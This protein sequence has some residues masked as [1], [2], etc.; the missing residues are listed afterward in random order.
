[1]NHLRLLTFFLVILFNLNLEGQTIH[2]SAPDSVA[3]ASVN[4]PWW[5]PYNGGDMALA[6]ESN[7]ALAVLTEVCANGDGSGRLFF[8]DFDFENVN[9]EN[10]TIYLNMTKRSEDDRKIRDTFLAVTYN[11]QIISNNLAD[12]ISEWPNVDT[13]FTYAINAS[14]LQISLT[15]EIINDSSFGFLFAT[16]VSDFCMNP[17][18]NSVRLFIEEEKVFN[19]DGPLTADAGVDQIINCLESQVTLGSCN[20]SVGSNVSYFWTN[21]SGSILS[22]TQ[23][24]TIDSPG[25]YELIVTDNLTGEMVF[26][27]VQVDIDIEIPIASAFVSNTITCDVF[28]ATLDGSGSSFGPA[29]RY[30]WINA[31][32]RVLS[33]DPIIEVNSC[34]EYTLHV[35]NTETGCASTISVE[36][37]CD[38]DKPVVDFSSFAHLSTGATS[39]VLDAT[40]ASTGPEFVY[41]WSTNDGQ[42][43]SGENSLFLTVG[44]EGAYR[45]RV[46]NEENGCTTSRT[47]F[48]TE[49]NLIADAGNTRVL[50]CALPEIGI[51]SNN[52]T[53]G[54]NIIYEWT[55]EFGSFFSDLQ[56]PTVTDPNNYI[57]KVIDTNTGETAIDD[58]RVNRNDTAPSV[59]ISNI[60]LN[61][62]ACGDLVTLSG[63]GSSTGSN[64]EYIWFNP[65]NIPISS[66]ITAEA[67]LCGEYCL[68]V[69]N[70]LN[71]C[72]S[73]DCIVVSE[74]SSATVI[75]DAGPDKVLSCLGTEF[76]IGSDNTSQGPNIS[77]QWTADFGFFSSDILFPLITFPD[78]YFLKVTDTSTGEMAF[79]TVMVFVN[80]LVP[81]TIIDT[82]NVLDCSNFSTTLD[83]SDSFVGGPNPLEI[84]YTWISPDGVILSEFEEPII[85]VDQCGTYT[86]VVTDFSN[87]CTASAFADVLC[88]LDIPNVFIDNPELLTPGGSIQ[89]DGSQSGTFLEFLLYEWTT[90][91]GQTISGENTDLVTVNSVGTYCLTVTN[92]E[93][94]CF[95][96]ECV[97]VTQGSSAT[98]VAD[99]GP[100]QFFTCAIDTIT[101]GGSNTSMGPEFEYEWRFGSTDIVSDEAFYTTTNGGTYILTVTNT[102][103]NE[104]AMDTVLV[105]VTFEFIGLGVSADGALSCSDNPT[106]DLT[107]FTE[108]FYFEETSTLWTG[109]SGAIIT[110]PTQNTITITQPGVYTVVVTN[111]SSGCTGT[112]TILIDSNGAS[113]L[114][115]IISSGELNCLTTEVFLDASVS[116]STGESLTYEWF[117]PN[118]NLIGQQEDI[119]VSEPGFYELIIRDTD[120]GCFSTLGVVVPLDQNIPIADVLLPDNLTCFNESTSIDASASSSG[121]NIEYLWS[122]PNNFLSNEQSIEVSECGT[123]ELIV[124]DTDNGCTSSALVE[125][126]CDFEEPDVFFDVPDLLPIGGEIELNANIITAGSDFQFEWFTDDGEIVSG[127]N[128]LS[129]TV[130]SPGTYCIIV[131]DLENGCLSEACADVI[132]GGFPVTTA[133]A[134]PD[135]TLTCATSAISGIGGSN[136]S[137]GPEFTYEW[138]DATGIVIGTTPFITISTTGLYTLTVTNMTTGELA[139][140]Q[141]L[142]DENIELPIASIANVSELN[143]NNFFTLLDASA[144]SVG[145]NF[146]YE[147][148]GPSGFTSTDLIAEVTE[149]GSYTLTVT[150]TEN[151]CIS[152]QTV[153]VFCDFV[154]PQISINQ[155][156]ELS[157]SNSTVLLETIFD[158]TIDPTFEWAGPAGSFLSDLESVR[159]EEP[160]EYTLTVTNQDNGC[161]SIESVVVL[162][163]DNIP[164]AI[165]D[166]LQPTTCADSISLDPR[167]QITFD[168]LCSYA[169]LPQDGLTLDS[170]EPIIAIFSMTDTYTLVKTDT[171]TSCEQHFLFSAITG[172]GVIAD[173][174]PDLII[175]CAGVEVNALGGPNT[176]MGVDITYSWSTLDGSIFGPVDQPTAVPLSEGIYTLEVSNQTTGCI[177]ID[178]VVVTSIPKLQVSINTADVSCF[179]LEDGA[180]DIMVVGGVPPY[181]FATPFGSIPTGLAAGTYDVS[182]FDGNE[183]LVITTIDIN[184]PE[185]LM[186]TIMVNGEGNVQAEVTG[187]VMPYTYDWNVNA[188]SAIIV[189]PVNG[190]NYELTL[191]DANGC[192]LESSFFFS[193][194]AVDRSTAQEFR[195]YPNP[196]RDHVIIEL[197][198]ISSTLRKLDI[199]DVQGRSVQYTITFTGPHS[200]QLSLDQLLSGAYFIHAIIDDQLF[201]QKLVLIK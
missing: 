124:T 174:G 81:T 137:M 84:G 85:T 122:G 125:V 21:L 138:T 13:T 37:L 92:L 133:D 10:S 93:N 148:V 14:D 98:V 161:T 116:N 89:I 192:V 38:Q 195:L 86:L 48:V 199:I 4:I 54:A 120:S 190:T 47:V 55:A 144:S 57:L 186:A 157:C 115:E 177:A 150:N 183:C 201:Y 11:N 91:D 193:M 8:G 20:T 31:F 134:G 76:T 154:A 1:M 185:E 78:T 95:G 33:T 56:F 62:N 19:T 50:N 97:E 17:F 136:T 165:V 131:E 64:I 163:D 130:G 79:D 101:I 181:T 82:P 3:N 52:T 66:G 197:E 139:S 70:T 178:N 145:P 99:A 168:S 75:A 128:T 71:F 140:D 169:W 100:D 39:L 126:L 46:T 111:L 179:G 74:N 156:D 155:P 191:T 147:W 172:D 32:D 108:L 188:D 104:I 15:E 34:Q 35:I 184:E 127:V 72:S 67:N 40:G 102:L 9:L 153:E 53:V 152:S 170:N 80:T 162:I 167:I 41:Q 77:Y 96:T 175:T 94:G 24:L 36:V 112:E 164:T 22:D 166:I 60:N 65:N 142:I 132:E 58:V 146:S 113:P 59:T 105:G 43:I 121:G 117:D 173:A 119:F 42:I 109:P 25:E 114:I 158:V 45:F 194:N 106:L 2:S 73:M 141:V 30:I 63:Q 61:V 198:N 143:C 129:P 49:G 107:V 26:D 29:Y 6:L 200:M 160:G 196:T 189:N 12:G 88:D 44:G 51:G 182:V 27:T 151:G 68:V 5:P 103:S 83:G 176:S 159:V 135:Q 118:G 90:V 23:F 123:F 171:S 187:G 7:D 180:A 87:G 149:C 110:D 28:T 18:I 16:S 69:T